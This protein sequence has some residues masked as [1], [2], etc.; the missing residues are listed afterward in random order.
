MLFSVVHFED[1][2][3]FTLHF[4]G[5]FIPATSSEDC[6]SPKICTK[7]CSTL[8]MYFKGCFTLMISSKDRLSS[9]VCLDFQGLLNSQDMFRELLHL[10]KMRFLSACDAI[11]VEHFPQIC[12]HV[13]FAGRSN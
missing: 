1:C 8:M 5:D 12:F 4:E 6:L 9:T 2:I 10:T 13:N 7:E 3:M 11:V